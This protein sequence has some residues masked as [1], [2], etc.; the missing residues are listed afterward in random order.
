[1]R[2]TRLLFATHAR[3]WFRTRAIVFIAR[4]NYIQWGG[5]LYDRKYTP[6]QYLKAIQLSEKG[7]GA[8]RISKALGIPST[9]VHHWIRDNQKPLS[10][11]TEN[12]LKLYN[13]SLGRSGEDSHLFGLKGSQH[14]MF[15]YKHSKEAIARI[16]AKKVGSLNPMWKGNKASDAAGR[17]RARYKFFAPKGYDRHH[18]DGNPLNNIPKNVLIVSRRI[19]MIKDGR[20]KRRD[21]KGR[22][23]RKD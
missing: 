18:I 10:M 14:P 9:T 1:M 13:K 7:L 17:S 21:D 2:K 5:F 8:K 23:K 16:S 11:W 22:F 20:M 19:H 3:N 4:L 12:E 15:G 6:E